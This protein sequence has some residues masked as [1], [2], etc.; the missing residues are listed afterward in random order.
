MRGGG[1]AAP[2]SCRLIRFGEDGPVGDDRCACEPDGSGPMSLGRNSSGGDCSVFPYDA[3]GGNTTLDRSPGWRETGGRTREAPVLSIIF[4]AGAAIV[5]TLGFYLSSRF[6]YL[7][8]H[9]VA[10]QSC[11]FNSTLSPHTE[12][13]ARQNGVGRDIGCGEAREGLDE[14][15]AIRCP[16]SFIFLVPLTGSTIL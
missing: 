3:G 2:I 5:V 9:S 8:F 16:W 7:L 13:A 12:D 15:S 10:P 4:H 14:A 1:N 6:S 11:L